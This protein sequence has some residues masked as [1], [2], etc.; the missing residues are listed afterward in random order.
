M[1]FNSTT[2]NSDKKLRYLIYAR[3]STE[4]EDRQ[5]ASIEAQV[6]ELEKIAA[7]KELEVVGKPFCESKSAKAPGRPIFNAMIQKIENGE[8][9]G[10]LCW[11]LDRLARNPVDAGTICW[12]LQQSIAKHIQTCGR[13]YLPSDNVMMMSVEFGMANQFVRDLSMNVKRGL[14]KKLNDGW[15]IGAVPMGYVN[16]QD[17]DT[18]EHTVKKDPDRFHLIRKMWDLMIGGHYTPAMI[19]K[20]ANN[21]WGFRTKKHRRSGNKPIACSAIYRLFNN[22]FYYGVI[23]SPKG[24]GILYRGSHEPM[25][26]KAEFDRVQTLLGKKALHPASHVKE[27]AFTGLMRCGECGCSVTAEDKR[28]V[29]CTNCKH[30]FSY[31]NK[32]TCP[33]CQTDISEMKNPTLLHYV[34]YHCTKRKNPNCTQGSIK[35]GELEKQISSFLSTIQINQKYLDWALKYLKEMRK[36]DNIAQEALIKSHQQRYNDCVAKLERLMDL[37]LE[38]EILDTEYKAKKEALLRDKERYQELLRDSDETQNKGLEKAEALLTFS[39]KAVKEFA[40]GDL[41]KKREIFGTLGSNLLLKDGII[42]IQAYEP[43]SILQEAL[44]KIPEASEMFEPKKQPVNT[45]KNHLIKDKMTSW[46]GR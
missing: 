26:T 1:E 18:G 9:D 16:F 44:I 33:K 22:P 30:K 29:I 38:G 21:E 43:F 10:I 13:G 11:K 25:I 8:A 45:T 4:A 31:I 46:Q 17:P 3:K 15:A 2:N 12:R 27:F 36:D 32:T 14:R 34:Y 37:R 42:N 5:V 6:D 19:L 28:Q 23:E 24:S 35:L 41:R 39:Q 7:E 20:I 40:N